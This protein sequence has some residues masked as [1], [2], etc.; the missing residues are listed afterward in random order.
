[1]RSKI[2]EAKEDAMLPAYNIIDEVLGL[3]NIVDEY[4]D[5]KK[6]N[7]SRHGDFPLVN[8][9]E[10]NDTFTIKAV[11]PGAK[12]E[13]IDLELVDTTLQLTVKRP[14]DN[15]D[16]TY[17][18]RERQSGTFSKSIRIPYRVNPEKIS[19]VLKDGILTVTLEK[20]DDA[21]PKRIAVK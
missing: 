9:R 18:R 4:F 5:S 16:D 19:A 11:V 1:L 6:L 8:L 20:S 2:T 12:N 10:E 7:Y 13:D 3:K 21:K 14:R 17:I 15:N